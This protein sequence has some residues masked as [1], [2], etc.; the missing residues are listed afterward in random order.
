[1]SRP[2]PR[3]STDPARR[4]R[5][6]V[7]SSS[8]LAP[9]SSADGMAE[10]VLT[11]AVEGTY[12]PYDRVKGYTN[13][14][15][16]GRPRGRGE[17]K[18]RYPLDN[19]WPQE[20]FFSPLTNGDKFQIQ[21]DGFDIDLEAFPETSPLPI[22]SLFL[23]TPDSDLHHGHGYGTYH[24]R[25]TRSLSTISSETQTISTSC[26]LLSPIQ[27]DIGD[28]LTA[29]STWSRNPSPLRRGSITDHD[30]LQPVTHL[31][32]QPQQMFTPQD[33]WSPQFRVNHAYPCY[34]VSCR[35]SG[36]ATQDELVRHVK[37]EHLLV[38]PNSQCTNN[39]FGSSRELYSHIA[40]AHP[41]TGKELVKEWQLL[42]TP[43]Q[44][45]PTPPANHPKSKRKAADMASK[46]EK[47]TS[48][49]ED[50]LKEFRA[51]AV[52]KRTCQDQLRAVVEKRAKKNCGR[53]PSALVPEL[54][55]VPGFEL[56][57]NLR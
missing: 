5:P 6:R 8:L 50:T 51:V 31:G 23:T 44:D 35:Q 14:A 26:S 9:S 3:A 36:F 56:V 13:D 18:T 21:S 16:K 12:V 47:P 34:W 10:S 7:G 49:P 27:T 33:D 38:C 37:I 11:R 29:R 48:E 25:P 39:G 43:I 19:F 32:P 52:A 40:V 1:M 17:K 45:P 55:G 30:L 2:R 20:D 28:S 46:N 22:P 4:G 41:A 24:N 54:A 15:P 53:S 57:V 42:P